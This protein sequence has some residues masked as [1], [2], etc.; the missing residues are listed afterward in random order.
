MARGEVVRGVT[1][2]DA[3]WADA[4]KPMDYVAVHA[5]V[6][7]LHQQQRCGAA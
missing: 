1:V 2:P 7:A 4:G 6:M 3:F 5:A